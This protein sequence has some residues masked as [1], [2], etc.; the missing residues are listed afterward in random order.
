[1]PRAGVFIVQDMPNRFVRR[2]LKLTKRAVARV[3][4][5]VYPAVL[6]AAEADAEKLADAPRATSIDYCCKTATGRTGPEPQAGS[7]VLL[8]SSGVSFGSAG[9]L[10]DG[11]IGV[12]EYPE[13][14]HYAERA[15]RSEV[16]PSSH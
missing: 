15:A 6:L 2:K 10:G 11:R 14:R 5:L 16:G 13:H 3:D 12:T 4:R 8:P 9:L 7:R 1:M